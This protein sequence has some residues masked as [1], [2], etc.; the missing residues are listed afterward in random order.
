MNLSTRIKKL[1]LS[2]MTTDDGE[3]LLLI[4]D[5]G[6]VSIRDR[7]DDESIEEYKEHLTSIGV[8]F[9]HLPLIKRR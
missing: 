8:G 7:N 9:L 6:D 4:D 2:V 1:E 5:Y 3:G